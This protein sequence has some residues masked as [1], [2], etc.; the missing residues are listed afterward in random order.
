MTGKEHASL[1]GIFSYVFAGI[2]SMITAFF[3]VYVLILGGLTLMAALGGNPDDAGGI[4]MLV[5]FSAV[6]GLLFALGLA[7]IVM[8]VRMGRRLRSGRPPT[9]RSVMV[10]S[11]M[12]CCSLLFGGMFSLPFGAAVGAYGI[13]FAAS[14]A[15][16]RFFAGIPEAE[17]NRLQP[18]SAEDH[19]QTYYRHS[20]PY[21]WR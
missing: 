3:G 5:I 19:T 18:P 20:E 4:V 6:F 8:N 10:T 16:K 9:Q 15:G 21:M 1:L 7:S 14:D 12:N 17:P 11:I 13:W 2:Q